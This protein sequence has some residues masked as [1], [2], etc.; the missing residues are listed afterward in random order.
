MVGNDNDETTQSGETEQSHEGGTEGNTEAPAAAET[1]EDESTET[2][3]DQSEDSQGE[4]AAPASEPVADRRHQPNLRHERSGQA[5]DADADRVKARGEEVAK[6][7]DVPSVVD[8]EAPPPLEGQ[9]ASHPDGHLPGTHS[10]C[11]VCHPAKTRATGP[12]TG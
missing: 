2:E 7:H 3:R 1:S 10:L 12:F 5:S 6:G 8:P 11:P 9:L 4:V